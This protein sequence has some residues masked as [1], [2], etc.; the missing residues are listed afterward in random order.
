MNQL[1]RCKN[2]DE[3]NVLLLEFAHYSRNNKEIDVHECYDIDILK[4]EMEEL[5]ERFSRKGG[6]LK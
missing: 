3:I 1:I 4:K 5:L 2:C 6:V